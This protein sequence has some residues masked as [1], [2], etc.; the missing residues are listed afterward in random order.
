LEKI[1]APVELDKPRKLHLLDCL[2]SNGGTD[3][4]PRVCRPGTCLRP[5][6]M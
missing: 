2:G 4:Q 5:Q 3:L 1:A 6:R